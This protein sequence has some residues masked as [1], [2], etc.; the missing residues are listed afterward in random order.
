MLPAG[1]ALAIAAV[2]GLSGFAVAMIPEHWSEG[3]YHQPLRGHLGGMANLLPRRG[4]QFFAPARSQR[5]GRQLSG[6]RC[7]PL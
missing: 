7:E 6:G 2:A 3:R 4:L 5:H 1:K